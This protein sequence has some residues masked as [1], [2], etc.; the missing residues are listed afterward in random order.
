MHLSC[1]RNAQADEFEYKGKVDL[2]A[3]ERNVIGFCT[4]CFENMDEAHAAAEEKAAEEVAEAAEEA[5]EAAEG[6]EAAPASAD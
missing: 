1:V 5:A 2:A 3:A 6:A 4:L